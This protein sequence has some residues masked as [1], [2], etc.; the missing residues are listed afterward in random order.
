LPW[1]SI[2]EGRG[3]TLGWKNG[4]LEEFLW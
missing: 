3:V 2:P 1:R 4:M